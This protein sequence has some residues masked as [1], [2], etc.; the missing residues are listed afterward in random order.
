MKSIFMF[1]VNLEFVINATPLD[2]KLEKQW[3]ERFNETGSIGSSQKW[4]ANWIEAT[5]DCSR[6][7][8]NGL[9]LMV[10]INGFLLT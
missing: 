3:Y 5:V 10:T 6:Q 9:L 2:V 4:Q 8:F 1:S 7:L